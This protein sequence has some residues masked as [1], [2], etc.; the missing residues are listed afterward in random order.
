MTGPQNL[1]TMLAPT[2]AITSIT[3]A[4]SVATVTTVNP[5]G[6]T[7][8]DVIPVLIAGAVPAGYNGK[9]QATVTGASTFTY[10]L[11]SNPGTETTPG[12]ATL[13]S[14]IELQQ[15]NNTVW[16]QTSFYQQIYVLELGEQDVALGPPELQAWITANPKVVYDWL[17]PR[18]WDALSA[19]TEILADYDNPDMLTYFYVTTTVGTY[20]GY[21]A[22]KCV[23]ALAEAPGVAPGNASTEFTCAAP[24]AWALGQNPSSTNKVPPAQYA[25]VYGVTPWPIPGN[26]TTLSTLRTNNVNWIW[27][28]YEGGISNTCVFIGKMSDG[29]MWNFWYAADW[30]QININLNLS[31][32]V[33]NGSNSN[34]N[35]LY[36]N[37]DGINRLQAKAVQTMK[38]AVSYGLGNGQVIA[39]SLPIAQFVANYNAGLYAGQ[40]VINAEPFNAYTAEN[41]NDYGQGLY[42]GISC[43]FIPQL[44]FIQILFDLTVTDLVAG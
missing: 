3:W 1:A 37:Q 19:F 15:M 21:A 41:P 22:H 28:G 20:S 34:I 31:N 44:G 36:Y 14:A 32:L 38:S 10:P 9:F 18:D 42:S 16:A 11:A 35:P 2:L 4:S 29:N 39:T 5:H 17:V 6:W 25:F 8:G 26:L 43:I 30:A 24:F 12:T 13:W 33:I 23:Y 7:N 27:T 40:I